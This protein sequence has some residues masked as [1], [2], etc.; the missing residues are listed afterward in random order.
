MSWPPSLSA[1]DHIQSVLSHWLDTGWGKNPA[2][3]KL[4][5]NCGDYM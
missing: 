1:D 2:L 3:K 4:G 5:Y